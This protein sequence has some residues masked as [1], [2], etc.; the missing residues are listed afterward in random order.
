MRKNAQKSSLKGMLDFISEAGMLKQIKRSGWSVLGI[1][2]AES[3][4]EHSFRCALIGY[5][6]ARSEGACTYK[7]L[8]MTLFNDLPEARIGDLHK[9]AQRYFNISSAE[10]KSFA[11]QIAGL[12]KNIK[13]ELENLRR[14]YTKQKTKESIV[15]R[16]ADILECLI[17][18]KEY[19]EQGHLLAAKFMQKAP[20][21]LKTKSARGLW[22]L[23]KVVNLN[24]WWLAL[25]KFKR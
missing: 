22:R 19:R 10:D 16:D 12:P 21:F 3:V 4:A 24:D 1:K 5:L 6:L 9:M 13:R 25:S 2:N 14:E 23:A 8:L 11:E 7:V 18:A 20:R 15:A 17:Q